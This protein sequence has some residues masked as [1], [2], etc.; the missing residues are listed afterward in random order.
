MAVRSVPCAW[1]TK[2]EAGQG[3]LTGCFE[4]DSPQINTLHVIWLQ[5]EPISRKD[6]E[7]VSPNAKYICLSYTFRTS[8]TQ[9]TVRKWPYG[10]LTFSLKKNMEEMNMQ[11]QCV[12]Q[13]YKFENV[14]ICVT[15]TTSRTQNSSTPPQISRCTLPRPHPWLRATAH[16]FSTATVLPLRKSYVSRIKEYASSWDRLLEPSRTIDVG[17]RGNSSFLFNI[18]G[19][20]GHFPSLVPVAGKLVFFFPSLQ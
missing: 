6:W 1:P 17:T 10:F 14:Y 18:C 15:T 12:A 2:S 8:K 13:F 11:W 3:H 19:V 20:Y 5:M 9:K 16:L 4:L 7:R